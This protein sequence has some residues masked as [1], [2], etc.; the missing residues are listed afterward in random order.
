MESCREAGH[1]NTSHVTI[2]RRLYRHSHRYSTIQIHLMLLLIKDKVC[3]ELSEW[4]SN[5]SHVT[6]NQRGKLVTIL[7]A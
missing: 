5:T 3:Y 6:I 4:H 2:N 7:S 1:S